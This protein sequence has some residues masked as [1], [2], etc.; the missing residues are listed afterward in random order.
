M[1]KKVLLVQ[2]HK[3]IYYPNAFK[4]MS[5]HY[6]ARGYKV[7]TVKGR[8]W[9]RW[10]LVLIT[11]LM[12]SYYH[13]VIDAIDFYQ[14]FSSEVRVGG[15]MAT[16]MAEDIL[17]DTGIVAH[18]GLVPE[19]EEAGFDHS[20]I[21]PEYG[22]SQAHATR[23][24]TR[25]CIWCMVPKHEPK[26][27]DMVDNFAEQIDLSR[28]DLMLLDNNILASKKLDKIVEQ[29]V[30]LGFGTNSEPGRKRYTRI[31]DLNQGND[32]R[33]F[34]PE[35]AKLLRKLNLQPLRFALD[36]LEVM[37][38]F[39]KAVE[40]AVKAGFKNIST[41]MLYNFYDEKAGGDRPEDLFLR[42]DHVN[43]INQK[44]GISL[45]VYPMSYMPLT[46][47]DRKFVSPL[48][49]TVKLRGFQLMRNVCRGVLP[50]GRESFKAVVGRN[51]T[52]FMN[53]LQ[54]TDAEVYS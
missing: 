24:C 20:V 51:V 53:N 14:N 12:S 39:E 18:K 47:R 1:S 27:I 8:T 17:K 32:V 26:F 10:D 52:E 37:D 2:P 25:S 41:Y 38:A 7:E 43:R 6:K 30:N 16:A 22:Y 3:M 54:R 36:S 15:P 34:T 28:K 46:Q 48:W 31:V 50:T 21:A 29:L 19:F 45:Y 9:G 49:D 23:G 4:K 11:T 42:L 33:L 35:K 5:A 13:E 40:C 44:Y